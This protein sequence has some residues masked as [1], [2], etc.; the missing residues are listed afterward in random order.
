MRLNQ[1]LIGLCLEPFPF[2]KDYAINDNYKLDLPPVMQGLHPL[3]SSQ[4]SWNVPQTRTSC[5]LR[6]PWTCFQSL[7]PIDASGQQELKVVKMFKNLISRKKGK[8]LNYSK[9]FDE[10]EAIWEPLDTH[11]GGVLRSKPPCLTPIRKLSPSAS[12]RLMTNGGQLRQSSHFIILLYHLNLIS[13]D[14]G[15]LSKNVIPWKLKLV[16]PCSLLLNLSWKPNG[17]HESLFISFLLRE[18]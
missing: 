8:F 16:L 11:E 5:L 9:G 14:F 15:H 13:R 3:H 7:V 2:L 1:L 6:T 18:I 4:S 10:I 17:N 12:H